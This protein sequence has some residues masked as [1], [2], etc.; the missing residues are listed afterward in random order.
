ML[1]G[2]LREP[3]LAPVAVL[4]ARRR[5]VG[6]EPVGALEACD[7]AEARAGGGEA[8]VQHGLAH[9]ARAFRLSER[10]VHGVQQ[11]E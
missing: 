8:I 10:P 1:G 11:P 4:V 3:V 6:G 9:P 2:G 7:L 5:A